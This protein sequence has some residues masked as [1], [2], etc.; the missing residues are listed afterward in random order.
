MSNTSFPA[1]SAET[2]FL[3][4]FENPDTATTDGV[5][6]SVC[7]I[8]SRKGECLGKPVWKQ[9]SFSYIYIH[10]FSCIHLFLVLLSGLSGL[11]DVVFSVESFDCSL[12]R[13]PGDSNISAEP[14]WQRGRFRSY[15]LT[16]MCFFSWITAFHWEL[17][18]FLDLMDLTLTQGLQ[19]SQRKILKRFDSVGHLISAAC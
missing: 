3:C 2:T 12:C 8:N 9:F 6:L 4:W 1:W 14:H 10:I 11:V 13:W 17:H 15:A 7:S 5:S 16:T 18:Q 19:Q